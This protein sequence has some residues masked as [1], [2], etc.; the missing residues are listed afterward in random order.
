MAKSCLL[1]MAARGTA[2]II[3]L[4]LVLRESPSMAAATAA[5]DGAEGGEGG[6]ASTLGQ[7]SDGCPI[8]QG[9]P[10]NVRLN[11]GIDGEHVFDSSSADFVRFDLR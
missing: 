1:A 8:A 10:L 3:A 6:A 7:M 11:N 5:A 2:R 9:L 4:L